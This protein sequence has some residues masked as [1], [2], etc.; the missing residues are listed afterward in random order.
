MV[1]SP[2]R[3]KA[4]SSRPSRPTRS[5]G[6]EQ[7]FF[8]PVDHV[9]G[10]GSGLEISEDKWTLSACTPRVPLHDAQIGADIGSE[11]DFVNDQEPRFDDS[12]P[13]LARNLIALRH[14]DHVN[15]RVNQLGTKRR[16]EIIAAAL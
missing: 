3:T 1:C 14:V 13:A 4:R 9:L 2:R 11:I 7:I 6:E 16:G 12:G 15:R 10:A 8:N 5:S